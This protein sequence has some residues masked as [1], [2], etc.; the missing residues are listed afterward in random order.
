MITETTRTFLLTVV[1]ETIKAR[2]DK[3]PIPSYT[4]T[5]PI[6]QERRGVFV[7]LH[8][9]DGTLRGCI[10]F[11]EGVKPLLEAVQDMALSAAFKDPRFPP[12]TSSEYKDITIEITVLSPIKKVASADDVVVGTHGLII[13]KGYHRGLL[14]PQVPVEQEWDRDAFISH[15]CMKAGLPPDT[16]KNEDVTMEV[17]TGEVFGE[18]V[19]E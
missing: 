17:F 9:K 8:T 13:T 7:T 2:L 15:T 18:E 3:E 10:G 6:V 12:L 14:L 16:W 1:R 19:G 11:I 4:V 5:D